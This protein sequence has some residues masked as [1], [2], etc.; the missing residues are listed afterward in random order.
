MC[1]CVCVCVF[2]IDGEDAA[3]KK[4]FKFELTDCI[5]KR[6][7]HVMGKR[8]QPRSKSWGSKHEGTHN[9]IV[10]LCTNLPLAALCS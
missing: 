5:S 1:V 7:R 3:R 4:S 2:S 10:Q 8:C 6:E 9:S